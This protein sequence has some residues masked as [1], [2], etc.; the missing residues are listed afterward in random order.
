M[1]G[2]EGLARVAQA[3]HANAVKLAQQLGAVPGV[4]RAFSGPVFHEFVVQFNAPVADVL[5]ALKVQ[6]ILGGLALT[7]DYPEL[8]NALLVCAT[9][10]KSAADLNRYAENMRRILG[11]RFRPAP[12]ALTPST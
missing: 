10:T 2:P 11:R 6:G 3:S 12:C 7:Q 5:Q 1:L 9:E 4:T 8:G